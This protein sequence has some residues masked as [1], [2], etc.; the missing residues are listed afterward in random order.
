MKFKI[1]TII[2]AAA[3]ALALTSCHD[4]IVNG[5]DNEAKECDVNLRS[6]AV[7]VNNAEKVIESRTT[8]DLSDYVVQIFN[9]T[10]SKVKEWRYADMPDV[11]PMNEGDY[12]VR[13]YSH[14]VQNAEWE[15]P[16]FL[17]EKEFSV[18]AGQVNEIGIVTC[19]LSN[20]KVTI[21][22]SDRLRKYMADDC[23]VT[24]IAN[25]QGR[26][27]FT[28]DETRA[29]FFKALEGS[30]TLVAEFTGT[31]G[32]TPVV[33]R[34]V[35]SDVEGGQHRIITFKVK[36]NDPSLPD[37]TGGISI[38]DGISLDVETVDEDLNGNINVDEDILDPSDRPGQ[39]DPDDPVDP[40]DPVDPDN[41]DEDANSLTITSTDVSFDE[42]NPTKDQV[43]VAID[44]KYGLEHLQVTISSDNKDFVASVS[45]LLPM[46]F[47]LAYPGEYA[48]GF[49]SM[50]FPTGDEVIG[51]THIDF[52]ISQ[53]VPLLNA[54]PGTHSFQISVTDI[55]GK[56]VIKTLTFKS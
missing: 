14:E 23:K 7:E 48:E 32:G 55:K 39:E 6:L 10:G 33:L 36:D 38:G 4:E 35:C 9:S 20:I 37:E 25:D 13:V 24:V 22:F 3:T 47:D 31:V 26:L 1:F 34:H 17:G 44:S 42:P 5:G 8:I 53:F 51:Q 15:K 50:G 21:K 18:A 41:P 19:K 45:E 11:F 28:P 56:Q 16:Y 29:G 54:F 40:V 43:I 12:K 52:N 27:E 46:S 49:S 2:A 30:S